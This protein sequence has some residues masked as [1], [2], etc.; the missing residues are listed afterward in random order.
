MSK[1]EK[2]DDATGDSS[3]TDH[4]ADESIV[5]PPAYPAYSTPPTEGLPDAEHR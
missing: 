4:D 5:D 1:H 3:A 2:P